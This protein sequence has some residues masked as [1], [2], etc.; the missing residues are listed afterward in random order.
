MYANTIE[1]E[2]GAPIF[3]P[4]ADFT[5]G[6][7]I[8]NFLNNDKSKE[9]FWLERYNFYKPY[10][11]IKDINPIDWEKEKSKLTKETFDHIVKLYDNITGSS[12]SQFLYFTE[13]DVY[14]YMWKKA[15]YIG[16]DG[17]T[18]DTTKE[19][20]AKNIITNNGPKIKGKPNRDGEISEEEYKNINIVGV[21]YT[22]ASG[23]FDI[24]TDQKKN[25][26]KCVSY[27]NDQKV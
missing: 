26:T 18:Y 10:S 20:A 15:K 11:Y 12:L 21:Y 19:Y 9:E 6:E 2:N 4:T 23:E 3:D 22:D 14:L 7:N 16:E 24:Y 25:Y 5:H 8:Y 27:D 1:N 13:E 17:K